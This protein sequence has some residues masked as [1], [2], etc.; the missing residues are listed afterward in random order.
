MLRLSH[1]VLIATILI[2]FWAFA[3]E[4]PEP[5]APPAVQA[6][7]PT[8]YVEVQGHWTRHLGLVTSLDTNLGYQ[9][10]DHLGADVGLPI[11]FVRSP[12]SLV[13]THDYV[14]TNLLGDAYLD[15]HY[16]RT[17]SAARI[18]SVLTGAFPVAS[19]TR[20]YSTG[21]IQV[22][23]FNHIETKNRI[24]GFLP[25]VN[26]GVANGTID[27]FYMPRPYSTDRLYQSLGFIA[28]F[29]G[30]IGYR[31]RRH[32]EIGVS[33]YALAPSGT[34]KVFSRLLAPTSPIVG[35]GSH[36]RVFNTAFETT[37]PSLIAR[38]NGYSGWVDVTRWQNIDLLVGYTHSI[39]YAFN[40][41]TLTVKFDGT[42]L[43]REL[44]G[45]SVQ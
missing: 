25:F 20:I 17:F 21:R 26:L 35:N 7:G 12:F 24:K 40:S 5:K 42:S 14:W 23:W 30:G 4:Q 37:G 10:N 19:S 2:P 22:D 33:G 11:L 28:D 18:T 38:D 41:V 16:T 29:E 6:Q 15:V 44:T 31:F 39:H 1:A 34:Q 13:T 3:Q 43:L 45:L 32:Y 9:L 8:A 27:R 36:N